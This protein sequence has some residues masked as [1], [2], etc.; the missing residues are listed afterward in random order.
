MSALLL[1]L[2]VI[3]ASVVL[4]WLLGAALA[5]WVVFSGGLP[6][7]QPSWREWVALATWIPVDIG[8]RMARDAWFAA[9]GVPI[10]R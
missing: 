5:L 7:T 9:A 3:S 8:Y 4:L 2:E 10:T 6:A 1:L